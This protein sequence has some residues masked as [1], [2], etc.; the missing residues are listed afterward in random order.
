MK[1]IYVEEELSPEAIIAK[2]TKRDKVVWRCA[3]RIDKGKDACPH[4]PLLWM[5]DGYRIL[6]TWLFAGTELM[7]KA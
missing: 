2:R 5:K 6:W 3:I 7:M 4:T 1:N